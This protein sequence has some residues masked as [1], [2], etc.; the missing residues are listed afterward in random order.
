MAIFLIYMGKSVIDSVEAVD[1]VEARRAHALRVSIRQLV[2]YPIQT[3]VNQATLLARTP[4]VGTND[5]S[6]NQT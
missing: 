1:L 4:I 6:I 2:R 5:P 3:H